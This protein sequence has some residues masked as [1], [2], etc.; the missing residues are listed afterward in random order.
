MS[1]EPKH[2][3]DDTARPL[4]AKRVEQ[5]K[6]YDPVSSLQMIAATPQLTHYKLDWNEATVEPSPHVFRAL[7]KYLDD[8]CRLHW[9]PDPCHPE[10]L[11]RISGY[12]GCRAE[13]LLV[14]SGSDDALA[15]ACQTYLDPGDGVVAPFPTYKHFLQFAELAGA[16]LRLI[17]N[18][19]PFSA[20]LHD[21]ETAIDERTKIVYLAN[22]NNPTGVLIPPAEIFELTRRHPHALFLVDEAYYEFSGC[23]CAA[24]TG[25]LPNLM[26]TRSFS[27][28]FGLA[29]LRIGYIV[30]AEDVI[31]NLRRVHNPKSI[32]K[33]AQVAA[34]AA[35][36]D[37]DY[38]RR[39]AAEIKRSAAMTK[40]FCDEH[41]IFC[42]PT[43]ANFILLKLDQP[44]RVAV[45]L[46][47][48]GVHVRDRSSQL[49]GMVR[50][51]LGTPEQM[52][53]ILLRL[54]NVLH[55]DRSPQP[56]ARSCDNPDPSL[57]KP[58]RRA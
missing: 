36:E 38:Y 34:A 45:R 43:H 20:G 21:L 54:E 39:Y 52:Q 13:H 26:I 16:C 56:E 58:R 55:A 32:N 31:G 17:R 15:L 3:V 12:V 42:R 25:A 8:G 14:T 5:A 10:L 41:N 49:P 46:R 23:S 29:G 47:Q 40:R 27:K 22:P 37:L 18:A 51:T 24:M 11:H 48:A 33:M 57:T 53:E 4:V 6:P 7:R 44:G 9:Y 1:L 35:L 2:W 19:D 28:C 30:A 50:I